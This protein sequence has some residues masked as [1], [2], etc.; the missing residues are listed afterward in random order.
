M[1][2][3]FI[4]PDYST[5]FIAVPYRCG[6]GGGYIELVGFNDQLRSRVKTYLRARSCPS[7]IGQVRI[8]Y[9]M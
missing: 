6:L 7:A 4:Y 9:V 3:L 2:Q 1:G 8:M 5:Y